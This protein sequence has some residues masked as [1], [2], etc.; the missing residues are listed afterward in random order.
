MTLPR[1]D[2]GG[3]VVRLSRRDWWVVGWYA[4]MVVVSLSA[5]IVSSA[6]RLSRDLNLYLLTTESRLVQGEVRDE[7]QDLRLGLHDDAFAA[8]ENRPRVARAQ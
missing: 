1:D 6:Y 2:D 8:L 7:S 4:L 3:D 5:V